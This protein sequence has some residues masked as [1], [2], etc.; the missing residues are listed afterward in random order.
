CFSG[1]ADIFLDAGATVGVH[2]NVLPQ[3]NIGQIDYHFAIESSDGTN[4][5]ISNFRFITSDVD[6][7]IVEDTHDETLVPFYTDALTAQ[8]KTFGV[9]DRTIE[10]IN[11]NVFP[12]IF[13]FTGIDLPSLDAGDRTFLDTYVN[14]GGKLLVTGENIAA[15]LAESATNSDVNFLNNVLKASFDGDHSGTFNLEGISGV[16]IGESFM[17]TLNGGDGADNQTSPDE[18]AP[19]DAIIDIVFSYEAVRGGAAV[20]SVVGSGKVVFFAFGFEAINAVA[21]RN[22][23]IG[24]IYDWLVLPVANNDTAMPVVSLQLGQNYPN[25]FNPVTQIEYSI[26]SAEN[27]VID[28][29]NIAGQKV[30]SFDN[31]EAGIHSIT[32]N[33]ISDTGTEVT[34]GVYFYRLKTSEKT[35]TRKMLLLK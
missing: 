35:E 6:V 26:K 27:A 25:P 12:V 11:T 18:I 5:T 29:Y 10:E 13:W 19:Y 22:A 28:I 17:L 20:K 7:L 21:D 23:L 34:S 4:T 32:W 3:N 14:D 30:R 2:A 9:W 31:L 15:D 33:G 24:S 16:E 8:T 1:E